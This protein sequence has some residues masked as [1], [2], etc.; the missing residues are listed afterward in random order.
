MNEL[1]EHDP[2]RP[3]AAA[4]PEVERPASEC[5]LSVVVP[6]FN[7]EESLQPLDAEIRAALRATGRSA[8]IIYVDD[9]SRDGS[10]EV[11]RT[12]ACAAGND[13]IR[14]RIIQFRRNFGQTAAMSAGFELTEGRIVFPLD[15]DGQNNPADIPRLLAEFEKGHD[16]VSGWRRDRKDKTVSRKFPSRIANMLIGRVSGVRLHDYGCTLKAY[17]GSM[18]KELHLYG[19]MHRFIPL[20]L[21][22]QGAKV[23]ELPVDHR[24]RRAGV[25]KYGSRRIFK[26]F[27]DLL[28]IRFMTRYYNR[29]MH[30][31]GQVALGFMAAMFATV[32]FM[33]V[34]KFG[35]LRLIGIAYT[36]SFIQTPL[37][38]MAASFMLGA[39]MSLFCGILA[40]VLIRVHYES[41][42]ARPYNV[43]RIFDSS[44]NNPELESEEDYVRS[45]GDL[46]PSRAR[47]R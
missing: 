29:P 41:R 24:P 25:S 9:C 5:E 21:A 47:P 12:L 46:G 35:W 7:E 32:A 18:L 23:T 10:L 36:A 15:A 27:L 39:V 45:D 43:E 16:V 37:P 30:F 40:E 20:Y 33:V 22:I 4:A 19:E 28:L 31:F 3:L 6:V 38:A 13:G 1:V 8:E 44:H 34:F 42:G 14:T 26:V 2:G 17:R 11:L